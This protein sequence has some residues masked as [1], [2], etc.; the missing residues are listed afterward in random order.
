[1][2]IMAANHHK[3]FYSRLHVTHHTHVAHLHNFQF[4]GTLTPIISKKCQGNFFEIYHG[5]DQVAAAEVE[6]EV[7]TGIGSS[8]RC[9]FDEKPNFCFFLQVFLVF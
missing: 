3:Y 4:L 2:A 6:Y 9:H 1:M 8:L 7:K 5:F